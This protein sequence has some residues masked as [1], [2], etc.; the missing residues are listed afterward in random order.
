MP[1]AQVSE[2]VEVL[3]FFEE[4]PLEKAEML[5]NIVKEKMRGRLAGNTHVAESTA[6][7]KRHSTPEEVGEEKH[8]DELG[9][10][11]PQI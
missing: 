10:S 9:G 5:F 2:E 11:P 3:R 4:A 1:R 8:G 7:K 6:K